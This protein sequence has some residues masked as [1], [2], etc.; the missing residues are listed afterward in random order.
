MFAAQ[1][2]P[3]R[4]VPKQAHVRSGLSSLL[5]KLEAAE[6]WW[7]WSDWDIQRYRERDADYYCGLLDASEEAAAWRVKLSIE[8]ARLDKS[9]GKWRPEDLPAGKAA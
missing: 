8:M 6:T 1:P 9:S 4:Y 7:Q 2:D 3:A 5:A